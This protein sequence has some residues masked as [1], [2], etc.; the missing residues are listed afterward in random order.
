M[1]LRHTRKLTLRISHFDF[2]KF[3]SKS[4]VSVSPKLFTAEKSGETLTKN[5]D[6]V[7]LD[8]GPNHS[9]VSDKFIDSIKANY[10][11]LSY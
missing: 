5:L 11:G 4:F 9:F 8:F 3:I 7:Y 2:N 10:T 6:L 1:F